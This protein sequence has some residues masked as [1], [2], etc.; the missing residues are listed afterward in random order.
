M[1][2]WSIRMFRVFGIS[3]EMHITFLLLWLF[4]AWLGWQQAGLLGVA[5]F[6]LFLWLVFGCVVLH[7][8]GH[9]LVAM[10]YGIGVSRILLLPFGGMAQ[11]ER[12]PRNPWREIMISLAGP[13][14]NFVIVAILLLFI[15]PV[16]V[17]PVTEIPLTVDGLLYMLLML[18]VIMGLFNLLPIFP[19]DGGRVLRAVLA[20]RL[21]YLRAT[22]IALYVAKVLII[23][24]IAVAIFRY[25]TPLT[26]AMFAFIYFGGEM[27]YKMVKRREKCG[28]V[29]VGDLTRRHFMSI[30]SDAKMSDAARLFEQFRYDEIL[31]IESGVPCGLLTPA[32]IRRAERAGRMNDAVGEYCARK[33]AVLQAGWPLDIFLDTMAHGS[34]RLYPVYSL[35]TMLGVL[36]SKNIENCIAFHRMKKQFQKNASRSE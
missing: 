20:L 35:G 4:F 12:I 3:L 30:D 10:A 6:S 34:Q 32:I 11:F 21:S 36:D 14:V 15:R 1:G 2:R 23:A 28:G 5:W 22:T 24:G 13:A 25:Q 33:F 26:A 7:E 16:M 17:S 8:F 29:S 19:M 27:E 9:S 31:V 18:N